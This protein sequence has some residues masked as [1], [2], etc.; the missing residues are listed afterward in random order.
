MSYSNTL[1]REHIASTHPL[2]PAIS[3][4]VLATFLQMN[5]QAELTSDQ[6][7]STKNGTSIPYLSYYSF[8]NLINYNCPIDDSVIYAYLHQ[9]SLFQPHMKFLDT[10]FYE[11]L[12]KEGGH[13]AS[14]RYISTSN[15]TSHRTSQKVPLQ[16]SVILIPIHTGG[17]HW[18]AVVRCIIQNKVL[19]LYA[20]DLNDPSTARRIKD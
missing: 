12:L 10:Y 13:I 7:I 2:T 14:N 19:F 20:D 6:P 3:K 5:N 11:A 8:S 15:D 16:S 17:S 9:L 4:E 1:P 18:V